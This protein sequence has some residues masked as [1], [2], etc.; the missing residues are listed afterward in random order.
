VLAPYQR[1]AAEI[2]GRIDRGELKPGDAI[3]SARQITKDFGV[4]LATA[5]KVL[6]TLQQEGLAT[7]VPG[8][9]TVVAQESRPV[10]VRRTRRTRDVGVVRLALEIA[11][12]E[13]LAEVSMRRIAADLGVATMSLYRHVPSKDDLLLMMID[14]VMA[15]IEIPE[16]TA[17]VRADLTSVAHRLWTMFRQHPWLASA[18]SVLRPQ[19]VPSGMRVTE[20]TLGRLRATGLSLADS[21]YVHLV[22]FSHVRGMAT[23]IELEAEAVRE[24]GTSADEYMAASR[25]AFEAAAGD[26]MPNLTALADT[27]FDL[28]LDWLF[29][30]GL[31]RLLDGLDVFISS[32]VKE[33][34]A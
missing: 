12:R 27:D 19:V 20:Y 17:D 3:P 31:N 2:R 24:S 5:T 11:D 30:F 21:M 25:A 23:A 18:L 15:E 28:D 32:R 22:L 10:P 8:I 26:A 14:A 7:A 16:P 4:A 34:T 29:D 33:G 6:A 1:I 9:G 13:G